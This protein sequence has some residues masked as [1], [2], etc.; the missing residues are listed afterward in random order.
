MESDI[1]K[2]DAGS[3]PP[4]GD[5]V[6]GGAASNNRAS[7][8][9]PPE[10][11]GDAIMTSEKQ[12]TKR[13]AGGGD[14][15]QPRVRIKTQS[16]GV[17]MDTE[18]VEALRKIRETVGSKRNMPFAEVMDIASGWDF[19]RKDQ[20]EAAMEHLRQREPH[21]L[22]G[23]PR[24]ANLVGGSVPAAHRRDTE[25][26]RWT[27]QAA[28]TAFVVKLY[29]IQMEAGRKFLHE[30]PPDATARSLREVLKMEQ[31]ASV[32][33]AEGDRCMF[34]LNT[35]RRN[36]RAEAVAR[37][38]TRFTT[39]SYHVAAELNRRCVGAHRHQERHV[40]GGSSGLE[41]LC[42]AV[43]RGLVREQRA[44]ASGLA[45]VAEVTPGP[46]RW[47]ASPRQATT[48]PNPQDLHQQEAV[49]VWKLQEQNDGSAWDDVTGMP[50]DRKKVQAARKEEIEYV[51]QK[52]VWTKM[53]RVEAIR[54]GY[55][56][57]KTR[58][59]D[60][61]KGDDQ[62]PVYRS[63]F[64]AKDFNTGDAQGLFA[65]TPPLEALRYL[66]HDAATKG[67][68]RKVVMI[69]DVARAFFE[70]EKSMR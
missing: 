8:P 3:T 6:E 12:G 56:V 16:E 19:R 5:T 35:W 32:Y 55:Q 70:I 50:L 26:N 62:N 29:K 36:G 54:R 66:I 2:E 41:D 51:R 10:A 13:E 40:V 4:A 39:N 45:A 69:N 46:A 47:P 9:E 1:P 68:E 67:P 65:G 60:I 18:L 27:E 23:S 28:H 37:G 52:N 63:R 21:L 44:H 24:C 17:N 57:I 58:W 42:R 53:D 15:E 43:H 59:I 61:N 64:V 11:V 38:R 25:A 34:G 22:I 7:E 49:G 31:A 48:H 14:E 33:T 20:R 30:H